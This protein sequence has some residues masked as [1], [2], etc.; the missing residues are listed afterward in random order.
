MTWLESSA[1]LQSAS[2]LTGPW[3]DVTG[4]VSPYIIVPT[5]TQ[6]FFRYRYVPRSQV[7][8]PYLM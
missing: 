8:N 7:S 6:Q 4:A 5:A 3:T 1:V 2:S